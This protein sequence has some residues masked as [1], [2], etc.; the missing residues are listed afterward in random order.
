M[1]SDEQVVTN[2]F[3]QFLLYSCIITSGLQKEQVGTG[4]KLTGRVLHWPHTPATFLYPLL[5]LSPHCS[6]FL[7]SILG[8][9]L[10][11]HLHCSAYLHSRCCVSP[12]LPCMTTLTLLLLLVTSALVMTPAL[13]Q[14]PSHQYHQFSSLLQLQWL[15]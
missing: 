12:L 4:E 8:A 6:A 15:Q 2:M 11:L 9:L 5:S 10:T 13:G 14:L 3:N 1:S 7:P